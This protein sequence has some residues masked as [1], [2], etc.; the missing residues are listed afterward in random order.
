[1]SDEA[2][3]Q[4]FKDMMALL[5]KNYEKEAKWVMR[6]GS[7]GIENLAERHPQSFCTMYEWGQIT[8]NNEASAEFLK[9]L[10]DKIKA[11]LKDE[12]S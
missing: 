11:S 10:Y 2:T 5:E 7:G 1:M 4:D 9:Q 12:I 6:T 3:E 8:P